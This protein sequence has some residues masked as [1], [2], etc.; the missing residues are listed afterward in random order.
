VDDHP[1]AVVGRHDIAAWSLRHDGKRGLARTDDRFCG[2][3]RAFTSDRVT[4]GER[5]VRR[6]EIAQDQAAIGWE[7]HRLSIADAELPSNHA[8]LDSRCSCRPLIYS[9][10]PPGHVTVLNTDIR[11]DAAPDDHR[12]T[13]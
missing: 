4:A 10:M 8:W 2:E 12:F 9:Q 3:G 7:G 6:A 1:S 11:H 5:A 13:P